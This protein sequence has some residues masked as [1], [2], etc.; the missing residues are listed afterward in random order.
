MNVW[1]YAAA[2]VVV[3]SLWAVAVYL[4]FGWIDRRRLARLGASRKP[5]PEPDVPPADYMI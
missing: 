5:P 1:A 4:V 2:C 3:P